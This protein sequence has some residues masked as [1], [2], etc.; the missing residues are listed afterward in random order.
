MS[1]SSGERVARAQ[2][3]LVVVEVPYQTAFHDLD[4]MEVVWHG[5]YARFFEHAR[6]ALLR[7]F[8]YDY[9]EMRASGY[10]WPIV[11]FKVRYVKAIG[12]RQRL[13]IRAAL[14]EW[15]NRLRIN[16][17]VLDAQTGECLT[18]GETT[19]VAVHVDTGELCL[20]SPR[21]LGQRLGLLE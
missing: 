19:Q 1:S 6:H 17:Q 3:E 9:P 2:R 4:P 21:V 10:A 12:F 14:V 11:D 20:V 13:T 8:D 16:Y 15:E 7:S 5:N 18:R